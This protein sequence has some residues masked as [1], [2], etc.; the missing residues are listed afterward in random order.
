MTVAALL[1]GPTG[2]FT[3]EIVPGIDFLNDRMSVPESEL[4]DDGAYIET[5][6]GLSFGVD[7][8]L[9][10]FAG[11]YTEAAP[12]FE[13][14]L[15]GYKYKAEIW[16]FLARSYF[17][18]KSPEHARETLLRAEAVMPDL[19][20]R[21]WQPLLASLLSQIRQR[22]NNQQIEVDFYSPS[23]EDL[24]SLFRLYFFLEDFKGA[25]GVIRSAR[26]RGVMMDQLATTVSGGSRRSY[27]EAAKKWFDLSEELR[28]ELTAHGIE[29]DAPDEQ[30]ASRV[31]AARDPDRA[32]EEETTR[33]LQLKID[34]YRATADEFRS[35]FDLYLARDLT[36]KAGE[37]HASLQLEIE[38]QKLRASVA[39]T[40]QDEA[41]AL[42]QV[43]KLEKLS[44]ELA[45]EL[46]L[47]TPSPVPGG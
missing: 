19:S 22:A 38:R 15:K 29:P 32:I 20:G 11:N 23:Q 41:S 37:V 44:S 9:M 27:L 33:I 46:E 3:Q 47:S 45:A 1:S 36:E 43:A 16:L 18:M 24:L 7:K 2:V 6:V 14:S 34:F 21:L 31:V 10:Y 28:A 17:H 5:G 35:L 40:G 25:Q 4:F 13:A 30:T 12:R 39:P 26:D 42:E 8:R